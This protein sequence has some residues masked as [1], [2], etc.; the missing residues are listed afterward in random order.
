LLP[1]YLGVREEEE[2]SFTAPSQGQWTA[3]GLLAK[4]ARENILI[5]PC[6]T[7]VAGSVF[8][9]TQLET[10]I[11][12]CLGCEISLPYLHTMTIFAL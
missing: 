5:S 1:R 4:P 9:S 8:F 7:P 2:P 3:F 11:Q 10:E 12:I 6:H